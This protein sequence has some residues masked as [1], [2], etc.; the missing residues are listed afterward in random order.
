VQT[1]DRFAAWRMA[2]LMAAM[3]AL[4]GCQKLGLGLEPAPGAPIAAADGLY[5]GTA[6]RST[7]TDSRCERRY[8]VRAT[9]KFGELEIE[10]TDP[11]NPARAPIRAAGFI[12][13]TGRIVTSIQ[14]QGVPH[15]VELRLRD[16][17]LRGSIDARTCGLSL[18]ARRTDGA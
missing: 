2:V 8:A 14:I 11:E 13:A 9:V 7:G 3:L 10:L 4:G 18:S 1:I 12:E 17:T 6:T 5:T 15:V 16:G